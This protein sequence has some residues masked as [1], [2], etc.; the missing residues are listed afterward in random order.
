MESNEKSLNLEE[1]R[2]QLK[3]EQR[4]VRIRAFTKNKLSMAGLV[5]VLLMILI[6][7]FAPVIA[8]YEPNEMVVRDR[9]M[10]PCLAHPFGTDSLGRDVLTSVVYGARISLLVGFVVSLASGLIGMVI[11]LYASYNKILDNILMRICDGMKAIP[12][13]MLAICLMASLGASIRNVLISLTVVCIPGIAQLARSQALSVRE[14][15]YVEAMD[16][17]GAKTNRILWGHI[18][19]N[20]LS[21]IIVQM[22]FNFATAILSEASLSFLG[23]GV[24]SSVPSWGSILNEGMNN[25][26]TAWWL[27]IFPGIFTA[28]TVLGLNLLG[29]GLRDFLD[30][31]TN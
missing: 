27:I 11:G 12:N 2:R 15:T 29:D 18:A 21:S 1:V 5:L 9:L 26:Y 6:A 20:I 10:A 3:K 4:S 16:A 13:I 24:P 22:T 28:L 25:I 31:L 7:L 23:A 14:Q 30:P 17:L 8:G 19:P